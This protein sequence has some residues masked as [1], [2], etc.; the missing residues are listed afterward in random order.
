MDLALVPGLVLP[1]EGDVPL[2]RCSRC[3]P[4][5]DDAYS[6]QFD[7]CLLPGARVPIQTFYLT[8]SFVAWWY[9]FI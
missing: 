3:D 9:Y 4:F 7:V 6:D 2:G 1:R 8:N 5:E